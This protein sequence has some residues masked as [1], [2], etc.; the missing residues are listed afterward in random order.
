M[1]PAE[2]GVKQLSTKEQNIK[3]IYDAWIKI[4]IS[5]TPMRGSGRVALTQPNLHMSYQFINGESAHLVTRIEPRNGENFAHREYNFFKDQSSGEEVIVVRS[6]S[7]TREDQESNGFGAGLISLSNYVIYDT[8]HNYPG[9]E[10]K[11]VI[12]GIFDVAR[13]EGLDQEGNFHM[14]EGWTSYHAG[15]LG[16]EYHPKLGIWYK[17][18]QGKV[19]PENVKRLV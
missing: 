5:R 11:P 10:K 15:K 19:D 3:A 17:V 6:N 12:A 1:S 13:G 2:L 8:I 16:Y 14:R 18:Y 9:F 7:G 4:P